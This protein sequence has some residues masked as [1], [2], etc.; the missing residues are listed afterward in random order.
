MGAAESESLAAG[1]IAAAV[2]G[3]SRTI[4]SASVAGRALLDPPAGILI[5]GVQ[6]SHENAVAESRRSKSSEDFAGAEC[7]TW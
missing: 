6:R 2:P 7:F 3:P 5:R 4:A 1:T